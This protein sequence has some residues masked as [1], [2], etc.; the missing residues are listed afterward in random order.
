MIMKNGRVGRYLACINE[1][2]DEKFSLKGIDLPR[3]D[4]K[5]GKIF[6]NE[7]LKKRIADK[8]GKPT[9]ILSDSG[10]KMLLKFGRFG[11]YL[12]SENYAN[13]NVRIPLPSQIRKALANEEVP[14]ENEIVKL[15]SMLKAIKKEEQEIL[16][17]VGV[18]EKCGKPFRIGRSR[19]GKYLA[20]TGYPECKNIKNLDKDGNIVEP[21]AKTAKKKTTKKKTTKKKKTK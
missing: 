4:I 16:S 5:N 17:K 11:S 2:C 12:E 9:D 10:S 3:E 15:D 8:K 19:W 7:I 18:C 1:E 14:I 20:C 13:D 6:V 21:K